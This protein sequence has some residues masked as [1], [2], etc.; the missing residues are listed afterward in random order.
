MGG[1]VRGA[2]GVARG[3]T[4]EHCGAT[5]RSESTATNARHP[6]TKLIANTEAPLSAQ[7]P[8]SPRISHASKGFVSSLTL[9]DTLR[10]VCELST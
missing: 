9:R 3:Q 7:E 4:Q 6:A 1:W 8:S 2:R 5:N 10:I